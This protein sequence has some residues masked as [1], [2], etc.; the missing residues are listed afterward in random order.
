MTEQF[1]RLFVCE[2]FV[3]PSRSVGWSEKDAAA[4]LLSGTQNLEGH[5]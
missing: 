3:I 2:P 4:V 1:V 5:R